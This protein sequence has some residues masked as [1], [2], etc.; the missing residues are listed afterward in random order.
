[1]RTLLL[2]NHDSFTY[3]IAQILREAEVQFVIVK[4]DQLSAADADK[5][6]KIIFSPGPGVPADVK[7]MFEIL[8]KYHQSKSILGICLGHQAIA[9]HFGWKVTNLP[10]PYHGIGEKIVVSKKDEY[11]FA[12]LP[13]EF[14]GGLYHSWAAEEGKESELEVTALSRSGVIM[15][16]RHRHYDIRGVQ[17]HPESHITEHG[18]RI[19]RNWLS[20]SAGASSK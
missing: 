6:D 17:F 14:T 2:D 11:L 16:L 10:R 4:N 18:S 9:H 8:D 7:I 12:G 19:I 3:N 13:E 5:Y 20:H 1:M 15:A